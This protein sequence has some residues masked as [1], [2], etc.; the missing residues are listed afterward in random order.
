MGLLG[1]AAATYLACGDDDDATAK[2]ATDAG[3]NVDSGAGKTPS[4]ESS[5][6]G[7]VFKRS[8]AAREERHRSLAE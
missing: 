4:C 5:E 3:V 8:K 7:W 6:R 1:L 2:T